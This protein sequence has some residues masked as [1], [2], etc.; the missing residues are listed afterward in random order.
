MA[1]IGPCHVRQT[2][3]PSR[4][5]VKERH[6]ANVYKRYY[7]EIYLICRRYSP[8]P[9]DAEDL[10]QDV[11]LRYLLHF[12]NF[13]HEA[14]PSTWMYRVAV[15]LGIQRWRK[16][17]IRSRDET[18]LDSLPS[19]AHDNENMLLARIT[20]MK[21][22]DQCPERTRKVLSMLH[23]EGRTQV[24]VSRLLGISR[25]T[26]IRDLVPLKRFRNRRPAMETA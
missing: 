13:R 3:P 12:E 18:E 14:R 19:C 8:K 26:V 22:F 9:D 21:I 11:F 2:D 15:N 10:A 4:R 17:R 6:F 20:L 5:E 16:E 1:P 7:R 24:E 23:I 25:A